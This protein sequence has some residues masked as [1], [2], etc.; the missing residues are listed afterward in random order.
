MCHK[1]CWNFV[2]KYTNILSSV[3]ISSNKLLSKSFSNNTCTKADIHKGEL[4]LRSLN[5]LAATYSFQG[6]CTCAILKKNYVPVGRPDK[7]VLQ[8]TKHYHDKTQ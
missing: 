4:W 3:G 7:P 8:L 5:C 1:H 2:T 6:A